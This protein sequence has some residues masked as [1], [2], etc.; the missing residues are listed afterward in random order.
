MPEGLSPRELSNQLERCFRA[1]ADLMRVLGGW[2]PRVTENDERLAFARD[3]GFRAEHGDALKHRLS[4]LRTTDRMIHVPPQVWRDLIELI[5]GAPSTA[6]LVAA[7][8]AVVGRELIA[9]YERL[10]IDCDPLGDELTIRMVERHLLP[11]HRERVAWA[12][13]FLQGADVDDGFQNAARSAL[14]AAGGLVVRSGNVPEDR[15][16][17][18]GDNGTGFWAFTRQSPEAIELGSEYRIAE[19]GEPV[20]YCPPFDDFG[21]RDVEVLVVHHGLMPEIA[22]LCIVGSL[23]HE[24]DDR[25]WAF[26]RD[27]GTQ[28]SDEVRHIGLLVRR[29]EQLGARTDVHPFPTWTFYDAVAFLPAGERTLVF[30][31]IVEGNVVETL[32]DRA[33][34]LEAVG[35][36]EAAYAMDWI[37][38]DES[39]H[40][41]NG[42]AWLG[43]S[44]VD[45]DE[46]LNR[47]QALLGEVMRQKNTTEKVFDSA[48]EALSK[49]DFYAPRK[50]PIAPISR[51]LGGF[52]ERQIDR[53]IES[54]DGRTIRR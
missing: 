12:D 47:G 18:G 4:R 11:D 52:D 44:D 16:E 25:P 10:L 2:T 7:V 19:D 50:N 20:S 32:H 6:D 35:N 51:E 42:M 33:A 43:E 49:G 1:E 36:T 29:L 23:L 37:S 46:L 53:L 48:S 8:Y 3:I 40:L 15:I 54:A 14:D 24:I 21:P 17:Q 41:L 38:A 26:Y 9:C 34:A 31:A 28:C 22:S 45:T 13:D 30:N 27:F 39:L 5:D